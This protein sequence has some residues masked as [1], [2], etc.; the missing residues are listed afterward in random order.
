MNK[1]QYD[2]NNNKI[3]KILEDLI[4]ADIN[5]ITIVKGLGYVIKLESNPTK[6]Y[7]VP[8][9]IFNRYYWKTYWFGKSNQRVIISNPDM[10]NTFD[11]KIK[12]IRKFKLMKH[13]KMLYSIIKY[14]KDMERLKVEY[15]ALK[16][17]VKP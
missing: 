3:I 8:T 14:N 2:E 5:V 13:I 15:E 9:S 10:T 6:M 12:F 17:E 7:I 16:P 1:E 11:L 4:P